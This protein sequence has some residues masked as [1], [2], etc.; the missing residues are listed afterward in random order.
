MS[1]EGVHLWNKLQTSLV[2]GDDLK[3]R[4][5][6]RMPEHVTPS[7]RIAKKALK[8]DYRE[9]RSSFRRQLETY[10]RYGFIVPG[11][12][13]TRVTAHVPDMHRRHPDRRSDGDTG[14]SV[15]DT[16]VP[17]TP[18]PP[19]A[20]QPP[21]L[22]DIRSELPKEGRLRAQLLG[23]LTS[24]PSRNTRQLCE[25]ELV[26][27]NIRL[28]TDTRAPTPEPSIEVDAESTQTAEACQQVY[29]QCRSSGQSRLESKVYAAVYRHMRHN[30]PTNTQIDREANRIVTETHLRKNI[31]QR[32]ASN[33]A[34]QLTTALATVKKALYDAKSCVGQHMRDAAGRIGRVTAYATPELF[35]D[36]RR[37]RLRVVFEDGEET[38]MTV[39]EVTAGMRHF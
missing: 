29:E 24:T 27:Q 14:S 33:G 32:R 38:W 20:M 10:M 8:R 6:M 36:D 11:A 3:M 17:S 19:M 39:Y 28:Q 31:L 37:V 12:H 34:V 30:R 7:M 23:R 5:R 35:D 1:G 26:R 18:Q 21:T 16:T 25:L 22:S 13:I 2:C 4:S 15:S 9:W